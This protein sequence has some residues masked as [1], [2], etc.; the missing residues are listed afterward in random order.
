[1][2]GKEGVYVDEQ[3]AEPLLRHGD[4]GS[5]KLGLAGRSEHLNAAPE[6]LR[7]RLEMLGIGIG[8]GIVR[9]DEECQRVCTWHGLAQDF[10]ALGSEEV[11][12]IAQPG[13][14]AAGPVERLDETHL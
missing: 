11:H 10:E 3:C 5:L 12:E 9:I 6:R 14:V 13:D 2:G 7:R 8:I 4:E 1:M